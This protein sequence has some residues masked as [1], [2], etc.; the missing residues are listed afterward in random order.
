[1]NIVSNDQPLKKTLLAFIPSLA[2][3]ERGG[4]AP[5]WGIVT[6]Y[7]KVCLLAHLDSLH[8]CV[9]EPVTY[10]QASRL[11]VTGPCY[12]GY[13]LPDKGLGLFAG[14]NRRRLAQS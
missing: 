7:S 14:A 11:K 8:L 12:A 6:P 3:I 13:E 10:V 1:M 4:Y 2:I 9:G 5:P